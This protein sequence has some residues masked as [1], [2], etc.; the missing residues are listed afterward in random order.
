MRSFR[1]PGRSVIEAVQIGKAGEKF[2]RVLHPVNAE[3]Q[4]IHVLRIQVD[5]GLLGRSKAA[6]GAQVERDRA[7]G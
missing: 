4:L 5:G 3:L 7:G 6:V 1:A 2:A